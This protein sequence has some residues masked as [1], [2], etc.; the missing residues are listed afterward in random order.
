MKIFY[1]NEF[2]KQFKKLPANIQGLYYRQEAI[3]REN[4]RDPRFHVKKLSDH[5]LAFSFRIT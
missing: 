2:R 4:W 1:A 3:F 5:P